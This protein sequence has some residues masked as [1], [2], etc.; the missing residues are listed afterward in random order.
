MASAAVGWPLIVL[1][2]KLLLFQFGPNQKPVSTFGRIL[3]LLV[4]L[5]Y[6]E[7]SYPARES[8]GFSPLT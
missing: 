3:G 6:S 5:L 4:C 2:S 8:Y 7:L 1:R